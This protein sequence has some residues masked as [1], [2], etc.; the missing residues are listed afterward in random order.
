MHSYNLARFVFLELSQWQHYNGQPV[1]VLYHDDKAFSSIETQGPII[2]FNVL[3]P[4]G[5][6][7]G[8]A[9]VSCNFSKGCIHFITS[10]GKTVH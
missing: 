2:N 1:A 6:Y 4:D 10:D 7:I 5:S 8:Y 9:E 3:R